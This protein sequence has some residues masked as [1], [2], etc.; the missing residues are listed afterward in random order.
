MPVE[1]AEDLAG[2]FDADE[3]ADETPMTAFIGG[4]PVSF[5]GIFTEGFLAEQPGSTPSITTTVP[6][7]IVPRAAVAGIAQ[8][9]TVQ[10]GD[11]SVYVVNDLH[12]KRDLVVLHLHDQW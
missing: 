5:S 3:F 6:R 8:G 2:F 11:G 7:V 4:M 1:S 9:D 10:R 12:F